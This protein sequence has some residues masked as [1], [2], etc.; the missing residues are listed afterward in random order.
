M[1]ST[2]QSHDKAIVELLRKDPAFTDNY[3]ATA[4]EKINESDGHESL[5]AALRQIAEAQGM[6]SIAKQA[7]ISCED[8]HNS[9]SPNSDPTL[10]IFLAIVHAAGLKLAIQRP[11]N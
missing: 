11:A 1:T 3:L 4:S 5:L 6:T 7:G 9:L 2:H 10:E 8:L